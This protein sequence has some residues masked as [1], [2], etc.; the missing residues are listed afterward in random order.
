[1]K[2]GTCGTLVMVVISSISRTLATSTENTSSAS[3]KVKYWVVCNSSAIETLP[4]AL[5]V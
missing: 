4:P 3:V 1:M 5:I 2:S